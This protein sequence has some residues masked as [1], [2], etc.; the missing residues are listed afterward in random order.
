M[1]KFIPFSKLS[2]SKQRKL[3]KAKRATW[4]E[5]NPVTRKPEN[6]KAYNRKKARNWK[7]DNL[8]NSEPF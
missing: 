3:N 8:H 4:G 7:K 6:P 2:K 5:I 1:E